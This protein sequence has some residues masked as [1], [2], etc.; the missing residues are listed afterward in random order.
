ML[1]LENENIDVK[2]KEVLLLGAG[3]AGRSVSKKLLDA[4]AKVSV[5]DKIY[6]KAQDLSYEF[7]GLN[8]IERLNLKPC[9]LIV[10]ATGVGMHESEGQSPVGADLLGLCEVAVDLIYAPLKSRF[11][12]IAESSGKKIINGVAML[13]YQAYYSE[14]MYFGIK[15]DKMQAKRFYEQYQ[16]VN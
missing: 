16:K 14:C 3:G 2:G 15:P 11:L 10:N 12:Q 7:G 8:V 1:M 13:F 9:Y 4:G 6:S 5:Y